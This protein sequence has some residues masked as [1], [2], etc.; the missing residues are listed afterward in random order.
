M[1]TVITV[2]SFVFL[3]NI[4]VG[5]REWLPEVAADTDM[6]IDTHVK[7]GKCLDSLADMK[8]QR[9]NRQFQTLLNLYQ[10]FKKTF[11][12]Y[13]LTFYEIIKNLSKVAKSYLDIIF[14]LHFITIVRLYR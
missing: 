10:V 12:H 8:Y 2:V 7:H 6:Y 11:D 5:I 13:K 4:V 1:L 9:Y 14:R 3:V